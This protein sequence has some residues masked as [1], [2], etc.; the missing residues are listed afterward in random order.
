MQL[1]HGAAAP[2][3]G[4]QPATATAQRRGPSSCRLPLQQLPSLTAPPPPPLSAAGTLSLSGWRPRIRRRLA[5]SGVGPMSSHSR[6]APPLV[7]PTVPCAHGCLAGRQAGRPPARPPH[8]HIS[9]NSVPAPGPG[10]AAARQGRWCCSRQPH[11]HPR[12]SMLAPCQTPAPHFGAPLRRQPRPKDAHGR[13]ES[14]GNRSIVQDGDC[15]PSIGSNSDDNA[16][17]FAGA[18]PQRPTQ[19]SAPPPQPQAASQLQLPPQLPPS[20]FVPASQ[21]QPFD[22]SCLQEL[23]AAGSAAALPR[24]PGCGSRVRVAGKIL[25]PDAAAVQLA[26][27]ACSGTYY[28]AAGARAGCCAV[29]LPPNTT[30]QSAP[31][32][33]G[34]PP[35]PGW[36]TGPLAL[37]MPHPSMHRPPQC[38]R[39][40][41]CSGGSGFRL[42]QRHA[43]VAQQPRWRVPRGQAPQL[44]AAHLPVSCRGLLQPPGSQ[45]RAKRALAPRGARSLGHRAGSNG[46]GCLWGRD[47]GCRR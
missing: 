23:Q 41:A 38:A 17:P 43:G 40:P 36:R 44:L 19:H 4:T 29:P 16:A 45:A 3:A 1:A 47:C 10:V 15:S 2:A 25:E 5:A 24:P 35:P 12:A 31:R 6:W 30:H 32:W 28:P 7:A 14:G 46:G 20:A 27:R 26:A 42:Q 9:A 34:P 21:L 22:T 18:P 37:V 8:G 13:P 39:P 33:R 11:T